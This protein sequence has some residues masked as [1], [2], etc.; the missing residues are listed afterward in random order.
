[1]EEWIS[2]GFSSVPKW[3]KQHSPKVARQ[4]SQNTDP[5]ASQRLLWRKSHQARDSPEQV[6]LGKQKLSGKVSS[7]CT[8]DEFLPQLRA[9]KGFCHARRPVEKIDRIPAVAGPAP[10]LMPPDIVQDLLIDF[11]STSLSNLSPALSPSNRSLACDIPSSLQDAGST[12]MTTDIGVQT[13]SHSSG[14]RHC[15]RSTHGHSSS[16]ETVSLSLNDSTNSQSF[17]SERL[18]D[19]GS[20]VE[21][22]QPNHS[23]FFES[24]PTKSAFRTRVGLC[25]PPHTSG[26]VIYGMKS[27]MG[28]VA[29]QKSE[30]PQT[31][32]STWSPEEHPMQ[33]L[34][35]ETGDDQHA[36]ETKCQQSNRKG[37]GRKGRRGNKF[38]RN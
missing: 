10:A 8:G 23:N 35:V 11:D 14:N 6:T 25:Y 1:M 27:D 36:K 33:I 32:R 26:D 30:K 5:D 22:A 3:I 28:S 4:I 13:H 16:P 2:I 18:T 12:T 37:V 20:P 38:V 29:C 31:K 24:Q 17:C 15:F 21:N 19:P 34:L 7:S 9:K